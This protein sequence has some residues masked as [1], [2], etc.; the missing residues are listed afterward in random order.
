[1]HRPPRFVQ[2]QIVDSVCW[3]VWRSVLGCNRDLP[4]VMCCTCV[5]IYALCALMYGAPFQF[6]SVVG[7]IADVLV[8]SQQSH[9]QCLGCTHSVGILMCL[10]LMLSFSTYIPLYKAHF[11]KSRFSISLSFPPFCHSGLLCVSACSFGCFWRLRHA[12][13]RRLLCF[14]GITVKVELTVHSSCVAAAL[15]CRL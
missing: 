5:M 12:H 8:F 9:S 1:M 14:Q 10:Q 2:F 7:F 13:N 15:Q 6:N 4:S 11:Y 3:S